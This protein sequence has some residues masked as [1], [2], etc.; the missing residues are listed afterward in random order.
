M[1]TTKM[2]AQAKSLGE[3]LRARFVEVPVALL[4]ER[5]PA[6]AGASGAARGER[7]PLT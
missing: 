7:S 2:D 5:I 6:A 4:E 3:Y 1:S